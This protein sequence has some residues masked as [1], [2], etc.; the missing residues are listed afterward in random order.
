M[1]CPSSLGTGNGM[2]APDTNLLHPPPW[3]VSSSDEKV[4]KV[5][6]IPSSS[7]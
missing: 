6:L 5:A 4:S 7:I 1:T 3:A 2:W